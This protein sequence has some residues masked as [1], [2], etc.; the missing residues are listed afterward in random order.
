[1]RTW[2]EL[3]ALWDIIEQFLYVAFD[4]LIRDD[5]FA[6]RA[7]F[8][9][10]KAHAARRDMLSELAKYV[11][12]DR[13]DDLAKLSGVINRVKA[14]ADA[15]NTLQHAEWN[16]L[17]HVDTQQ[18]ELKRFPMTPQIW[19]G[20]NRAY[21]K[22]DIA[23]VVNEMKDTL[24]AL[25]DVVKPLADAKQAKRIEDWKRRARPEEVAAYEAMVKREAAKQQSSSPDKSQQ[26]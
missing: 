8:Y 2:G 24:R 17:T 10:Q 14:R 20:V 22:D 4:A 5:P 18:V 7:V 21:S 16:E 19:D 23:R 6:T 15:R 13:P 12:K 11:L 26:P 9:S 25:R 3:N 1:M